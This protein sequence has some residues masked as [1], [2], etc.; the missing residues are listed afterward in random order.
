MVTGMENN[1]EKQGKL[2]IPNRSKSSSFG[3]TVEEVVKAY[4]RFLEVRHS[5]HLKLFKNRLRTDP[6]AAK[7]EAV[8]FSW[9]RQQRCR[10]HVSES[11]GIGGADYLCM[12]ESKASFLIEVTHLNKDA[13]ERRSGW[14]NELSEVAHSFSMITPNLWSKAR[15]KAFQLAEQDAPRVLAIC[16]AHIGASALLGTLAAE[17]LM[18]SEPRIEVPITLEGEPASTRT[19]TDLKNSS[20]L[21]LR[22]ARSF[23]SAKVSPQSC[24]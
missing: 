17:W 9:L 23:P 8:V 20:F 15:A 14:P 16:S 11:P 5:D 22:T 13:V 1:E 12:P 6:D 19:V 21:G 2:W 3:D 7:A 18:I 24:S 4:S 10:P